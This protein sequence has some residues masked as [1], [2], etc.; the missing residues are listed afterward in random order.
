MFVGHTCIFPFFL[1]VDINIHLG[2]SISKFN[3]NSAKI[4]IDFKNY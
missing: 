2:K 1:F 3:L 4:N